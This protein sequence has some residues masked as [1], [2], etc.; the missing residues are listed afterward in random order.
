MR[1]DNEDFGRSGAMEPIGLI[2]RAEID[3]V[4]AAR[5]DFNFTSESVRSDNLTSRYFLVVGERGAIKLNECYERSQGL[6]CVN[7]TF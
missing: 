3:E 7:I 5:C 4:E 6:N 2:G 1:Q